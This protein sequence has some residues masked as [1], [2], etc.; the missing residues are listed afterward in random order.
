[1][2]RVFSLGALFGVE[3]KPFENFVYF[4]VCFYLAITAFCF[5]KN[6][7]TH[8]LSVFKL[9]RYRINRRSNKLHKTCSD[10]TKMNSQTYSQL[11]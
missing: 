9:I 1:M 2:L 6:G 10:Q 3:K 5:Q 4:I 7:T 11:V 8:I